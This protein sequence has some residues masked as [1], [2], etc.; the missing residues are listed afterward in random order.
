MRAAARQRG[1]GRSVTNLML[2]RLLL[3]WLCFI[4]R[5]VFYC[6][7]L[8]LWEGFDEWAHFGVAQRMRCGSST[9][10]SQTLLGQ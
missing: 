3:I 8:P 1:R 9:S 4:F 5:G 10:P 7:F 2:K 6:S